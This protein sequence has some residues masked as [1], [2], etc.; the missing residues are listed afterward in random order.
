MGQ[1]SLTLILFLPLCPVSTYKLLIYK[2]IYILIKRQHN[3]PNPNSFANQ[4]WCI[5]FLSHPTPLII[6]QKLPAFLESLMPLIN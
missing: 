6:P 3:N 2:R 1:I 5:D 4:V